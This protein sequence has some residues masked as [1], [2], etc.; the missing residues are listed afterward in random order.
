VAPWPQA[1]EALINPEA[2]TGMVAIME[3][4]KAIRNMRAEVKAAPGKKVPAIL[5]V[6]KE[7]QAVVTKNQSYIK[8]MGSVDDLTVDSLTG[9]KPENAMATVTAGIEVYL[10]LK[11]LI[12]V[13]KE[14]QRLQ[15]EL[16]SLT[17]DV[18][19]IA[20]KLGNAGFLAQAPA[21]VVA[22]EQAKSQEFNEKILAI[23]ERLVYL[24]TL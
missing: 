5:L 1:Q 12:D 15:K 6:S 2:E 13:E 14:N 20:G 22:K 9:N 23:K 11:G 21:E 18:A 4:I 24:K 7:L 3:T 17:K 19:R 8:L 16:E 10:P